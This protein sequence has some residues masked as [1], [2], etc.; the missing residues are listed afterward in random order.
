LSSGEAGVTD[1]K[2]PVKER[3]P[4]ESPSSTDT[5]TATRRQRQALVETRATAWT[6]SCGNRVENV[7][8]EGLP[9]L[10]VGQL[11]VIIIIIVD[12]LGVVDPTGPSTVADRHRREKIVVP[13]GIVVVI[14]VVRQCH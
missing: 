14:V 9:F 6:T 11:E 13:H 8:L 1:R 3:I 12:I 7:A 2:A 5:A 10:R 4:V